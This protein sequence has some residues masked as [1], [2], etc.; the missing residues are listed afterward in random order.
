M[1]IIDNFNQ[2]TAQIESERGISKDIL[3]S[4]VEQALVAACRKRFPEEALLE[5][6]VDP[7]TGEARIYQLKTVAKTVEDPD[8]EATVKEAKEWGFEGSIGEKIRLEVT[9]SDF[10]RTAALTAKQVIIQRIREAEKEAVF[11][12]FKDRV[13]Q[14]VIGTVQRVENQNYLINLGRAEAVLGYRDQI[15]GERFLPKEKIKVFIVDLDKNAR[16]SFIQISRSHPGLLKALLTQEIPEIQDGIIEIMSVS[17]EP[18]KRAKVAVKSNNASIGAVGTCVGHMGTRIQSVTKELGREKIDVLEWSE[19]PKTFIANALKPAKITNIIITNEEN[20][21]ATVVVPNDQ[22]SLA[23]GKGG[24]NVRL[25]VKLTGWK[26][27]VVSEGGEAQSPAQSGSMT[28]LEKL[29]REKARQEDSDAQAVN[30]AVAEA[31]P[32]VEEVAQ[33][34]QEVMEES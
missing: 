21:E 31:E 33:E 2:V 32:Q 1:I 8:T 12:D 25:S 23:I 22:L 26:M 16:G 7:E 17:R 4:A 19:D 6:T 24:V 15:Q 30:D 10:G 9:P 20:R 27:D 34:I 29:Q 18:G 5:A 14:I 3:V 13:G 11:R 28:L